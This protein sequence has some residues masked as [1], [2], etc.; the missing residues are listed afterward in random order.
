MVSSRYLSL[1]VSFILLIGCKDDDEVVPGGDEARL[2]HVNVADAVAMFSEE[3]T[4]KTIEVKGYKYLQETLYKVAASGSLIE[5][6]FTIEGKSKGGFETYV[7]NDVNDQY[8]LISFYRREESYFINKKT[9]EAIGTKY[10]LTDELS[11]EYAVFQDKYFYY[12]DVDGREHVIT[13]Y[14]REEVTDTEIVIDS[15]DKLYVDREG[16]LYYTLQ[17]EL[18]AYVDGWPVKVVD[19][20][21]L[22]YNDI[23]GNLYVVAEDEIVYFIGDGTIKGNTYLTMS[24]DVDFKPYASAIVN[25]GITV[26]LF[27]DEE[28]DCHLYNFERNKPMMKVRENST[29]FEAIAED[30]FG[31]TLSLFFKE[32]E[33][34]A[35]MYVNVADSVRTETVVKTSLDD[36]VEEI[37]AI[38]EDMVIIPVCEQVGDIGCLTY[39]KYMKKDGSVHLLSE[40]K[41]YGSIIKL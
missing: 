4:K 39:I 14:L 11:S 25:G 20:C 37:Y 6:G 33:Q 16:V 19:N 8:F 36:Q 40:E 30:S 9:G 22:V 32:N 35:I 1:I 41:R 23:Y 3:D 38:N 18:Y 12:S 7:V 29:S 21:R 26:G 13:R 15:F 34:R 2:I 27:K 31:T 10:I 5:A 28:G 17:D 24:T